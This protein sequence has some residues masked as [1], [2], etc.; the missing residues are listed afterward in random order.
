MLGVNTGCCP[1]FVPVAPMAVD[2]A[3][4]EI[5]SQSVCEVDREH[6][7]RPIP[8]LAADQLA[9]SCGSRYYTGP[10]SN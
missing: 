7:S 6:D 4:P 8:G 9:E 1:E 5:R 2:S 3:D 10:A